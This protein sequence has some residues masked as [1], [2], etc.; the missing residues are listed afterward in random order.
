MFKD[1]K[2]SFN[3]LKDGSFWS[4]DNNGTT[5]IKI[6]NDKWKQFEREFS[7]CFIE[8]EEDGEWKEYADGL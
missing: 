7:L 4:L 6:P 2:T 1:L 8:P 3:S 5:Y